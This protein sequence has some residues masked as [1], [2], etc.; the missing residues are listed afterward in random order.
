[1]LTFSTSQRMVYSILTRSLEYSNAIHWTPFPS[2][3]TT[4]GVVAG[5]GPGAAVVFVEAELELEWVFGDVI[6]GA[7]GGG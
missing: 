6:E 1:M 7:E 4:N 3:R 2:W 5:M